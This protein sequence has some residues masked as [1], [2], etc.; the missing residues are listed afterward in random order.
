MVR[1]LEIKDIDACV[2]V[3]QG[4]FE[5]ENYSYDVVSYLN[6]AFKDDQFIKPSFF[7]FEEDAVIKGVIG[8]SLTGFDSGVFGIFMCYVK[9][10]FQ[11]CG[12]GKALTTKA[13]DEI[14]KR[15]GLSVLATTRRAWHFERFGFKKISSPYPDWDVMQLVF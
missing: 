5:L 13:L 2:A 1:A 14:R 11:G 10:E 15:G 12:I 9:P 7:V 4:I 8:F 3:S 6:A